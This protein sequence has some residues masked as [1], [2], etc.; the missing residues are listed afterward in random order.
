M[1]HARGGGGVGEGKEGGGSGKCQRCV[2]WA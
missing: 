1:R 2:S